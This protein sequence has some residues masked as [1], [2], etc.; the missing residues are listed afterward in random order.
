MHCFILL[1]RHPLGELVLWNRLESDVPLEERTPQHFK[2]EFYTEACL[3][4]CFM[5]M[6][7][8]PPSQKKNLFEKEKHTFI[9]LLKHATSFFIHHRSLFIFVEWLL[10]YSIYST[11]A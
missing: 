4:I 9:F 1:S 2:A 3:A 11:F 5:R 8:L 10:R 6:F 7:M